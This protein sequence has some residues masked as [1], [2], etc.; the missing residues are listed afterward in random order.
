MSERS[1][2]P[3]LMV[4]TTAFLG[5][6]LYAS[7]L[8]I[9]IALSDRDP[10]QRQLDPVIASLLQAT[11]PDPRPAPRHT[12]LGDDTMLVDIAAAD[13][14]ALAGTSGLFDALGIR[15]TDEVVSLDGRSL[16]R[17]GTDAVTALQARPGSFRE[18]ELQRDG[19]P[20][21]LLVV[22]H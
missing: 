3:I 1:S 20:L 10:P 21:R 13:L 15:P 9:S 17:V 12:P 18:L 11:T 5:G 8:P 4:A 14:A 6:A 7:I 16:S 22:A 19:A 2:L